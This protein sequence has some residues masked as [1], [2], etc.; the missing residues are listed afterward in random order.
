M[1]L[2]L[3]FESGDYQYGG[4][5]YVKALIVHTAAESG[6]CVGLDLVAAKKKGAQSIHQL[7]ATMVHCVRRSAVMRPMVC[8]Q[9]SA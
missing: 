7:T 9:R 2:I 3:D 4:M 8:H 5:G 6:P 1:N